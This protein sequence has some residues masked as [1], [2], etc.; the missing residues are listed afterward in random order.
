[1]TEPSHYSLYLTHRV[2]QFMDQTRSLSHKTTMTVNRVNLVNKTT[3][4]LLSYTHNPRK[5]A[6]QLNPSHNSTS[7]KINLNSLLLFY[8]GLSLFLSTLT[9]V[10]KYIFIGSQNKT[11]FEFFLKNKS[12]KLA[13]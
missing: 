2:S 11:T 10:R 8:V 12:K 1:M 6:L 7:I 3:I 4:S 9:K 5:A 13:K